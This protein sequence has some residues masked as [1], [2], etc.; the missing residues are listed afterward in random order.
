M[1]RICRAGGGPATERQAGEPVEEGD[2][3]DPLVQ[4]AFYS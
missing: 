3:N 2:R 1:R 4:R